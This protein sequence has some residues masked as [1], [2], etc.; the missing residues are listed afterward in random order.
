MAPPSRIGLV[1]V[2]ELYRTK[3]AVQHLVSEVMCSSVHAAV[4]AEQLTV[5]GAD[6]EDLGKACSR[7][8]SARLVPVFP[9]SY[10]S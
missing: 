6:R 7:H 2:T 4:L 10:E 5:L 1:G 8:L 3:A 9:I